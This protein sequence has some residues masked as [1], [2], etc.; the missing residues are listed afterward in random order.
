MY[1]VYI[2]NDNIHRHNTHHG[3]LYIYVYIYMLPIL[4]DTVHPRVN[5]DDLDGSIMFNLWGRN[6]RDE[7]KQSETI[8]SQRLKGPAFGRHICVPFLWFQHVL[9]HIAKS[10]H[11]QQNAVEASIL[12]DSKGN[13]L[14]GGRSQRNE[15]CSDAVSA[16]AASGTA[17]PF[18]GSSIGK[19]LYLHRRFHWIDSTSFYQYWKFMVWSSWRWHWMPSLL[20][21][22][23]QRFDWDCHWWKLRLKTQP[24]E[25]G[26]QHPKNDEELF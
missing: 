17:A 20:V 3:L 22:G 16:G 25:T 26:S 6:K 4:L 21:F 1:T 23:K 8:I 7:W 24:G 14:P 15:A 5:R 19:A 2:Y 11:E 18:A 9:T 12:S 13:H 10:V